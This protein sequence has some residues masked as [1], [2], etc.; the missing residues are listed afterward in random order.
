MD[1][2][3]VL[4]AEL[5]VKPWQVEAAV[6]LIDEGNTIPFISRY[7]KEAT[8]SLNDEILRNLY[9]RLMYLRSLNDRKA[10]VLASIEEQGKL[11]AELNAQTDLT[12]TY[13]GAFSCTAYCSEEYAH[14]CG[15]GHGITSSGAKV[16]PGVTVAADISVLPYGTVVYIE[17]VG[18][19]VVQDTG[20]AVKGNKL[21]VAVNTHAEALSWSGWGSRRVWIIS[22]GVEP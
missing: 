17:G 16:Q 19:R 2:N 18:L 6:K 14:I 11:T 4:A 7:R 9:D 21:D 20:S 1:M 12:L 5:N 8:G 22:G 10:V 3:Q 15:E 13:A